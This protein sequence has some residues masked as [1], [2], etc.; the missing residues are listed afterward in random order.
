MIVLMFMESNTFLCIADARKTTT[1]VRWKQNIA[2]V[3]LHRLRTYSSNSGTL[4]DLSSLQRY[5]I[6]PQK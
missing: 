3:Y 2:V 5:S 4:T 6:K 1:Q